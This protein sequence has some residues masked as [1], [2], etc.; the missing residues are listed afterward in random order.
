MRKTPLK[1]WGQA[2][3]RS[4]LPALATLLSGINL[5]ATTVTTISGGAPPQFYGYLNGD[6][7]HKALFHTPCGLA[8]DSTGNYLFVADRDN[9]AVR[10]LDIGAGLTWTF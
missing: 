7:L 10:Y 8:I 6:T 5:H 4:M 1:L 3:C 9:N 2:L